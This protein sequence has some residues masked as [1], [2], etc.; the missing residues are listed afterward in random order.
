MKT[1]L[2]TYIKL[3]RQ[4][5]YITRQ[6]NSTFKQSGDNSYHHSMSSPDIYMVC[7][8]RTEN[9]KLEVGSSDKVSVLLYKKYV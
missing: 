5:L 7:L 2:N 1:L 9:A 4:Q 6:T 8:P 3:Y